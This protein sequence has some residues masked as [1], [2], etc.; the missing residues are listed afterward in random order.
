MISK[1]SNPF[2]TLLSLLRIKFTKH[3]SSKLYEEHPNKNNLLGLSQMLCE[4][5]IANEGIVVDDKKSFDLLSLN[6]PFVAQMGT[7][8]AV[9]SKVTDN[10]VNCILND[11]NIVI[12]KNQFINSWKGF[13][14]LVE[15]NEDSIEPNWKDHRRESFLRKIKYGLLLGAIIG[16][17]VLNLSVK[18][19]VNAGLAIMILL[20]SCGVYISYLL[21]LK[22]INIQGR[23]VDKL[24]S[25]F[26]EG[27]CNDVLNSKAA[28]LFGI[29]SWSE[30]GAGY[31]I[32]NLIIIC[33][34]PNLIP[35]FVSVN[36]LVLPYSLW[37]I[38]YQKFKVRQWCI[39]CLMVQL[40]IWLIFIG[41]IILHNLM[42][43]HFSLEEILSTGLIF[44]ISILSVNAI[45]SLVAQSLKGE[46]FRHAF[47]SLRLTEEVFRAQ[48]TKQAQIKIGKEESKIIFGNPK[49][50]S[51]ITIYSNPHCNPCARL[52]KKINM[53]LKESADKICIQYIF[54]S[55]GS[56]WEDSAKR[57]ISIYLNNDTARAESIY[58]EWFESGKNDRLGFAKKYEMNINAPN[59]LEEY[60]KH[61]EWGH[62][63]NL[64]STPTVF[65]NGYLLPDLYDFEDLKYFVG[66]MM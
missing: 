28:Q 5:N 59:V 17:F 30:I 49:A 31:F 29:I 63:N 36:L 2:T 55:F 21:L 32:G 60:I 50:N 13:L 40:I 4:Y 44:S 45:M 10:K 37:S 3:Y 12:D 57:L 6:L 14:L 38:W 41:N 27:D 46:K 52:H 18:Q 20:N 1:Y 33:F 56:E 26:I 22:Q 35:Y 34:I 66:F 8:F 15:P 25:I 16:A 42:L 51:W 23:I 64:E 54:C 24:C 39:L 11:F 47:N 58:N 61:I 9:V 48:L 43:P 7:G 65:I 53:L 19:V 62:T